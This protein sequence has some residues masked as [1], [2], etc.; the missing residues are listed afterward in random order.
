MPLRLA[1]DELPE[2]FRPETTTGQLYSLL[3]NPS[4][5]A[6]EES[7]EGHIAKPRP[8]VQGATLLALSVRSRH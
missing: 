8:L 1:T 5:E 6:P 2:N 3:S 4:T 7:T